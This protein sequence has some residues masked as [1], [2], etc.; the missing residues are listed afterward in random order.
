MI[1]IIGIS[2]G[3][4]LVVLFVSAFALGTYYNYRASHRPEQTRFSQ[5]GLPT[6]TLDGFY[7]GNRPGSAW[8]GKTFNGSAQS[9]INN[10]TDGDKY[11]FKTLVAKGLKDD[12]QVLKIDYNQ[13][14]NPWWLRYVVDELVQTSDGKYLGKVNLK[15][16]PGL[17][18]TITY[19][20]LTK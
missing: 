9:G 1:K 5:G 13:P 14:H 15:I 16:L 4:G 6:K 10:F 2:L 11:V 3:L 7:K 18:I 17:P 20:E 19:F 12:K 8:Q